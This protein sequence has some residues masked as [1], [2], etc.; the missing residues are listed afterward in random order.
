MH[1]LPLRCS[2]GV[3]TPTGC[4]PL[5][6]GLS[7]PISRP[8]TPQTEPRPH[9]GVGDSL[10]SSP[11]FL[12]TDIHNSTQMSYPYIANMNSLPLPLPAEKIPPTN[13]RYTTS[14]YVVRYQL[15]GRVSLF[16]TPC[17]GDVVCRTRKTKRPRRNRNTVSPRSIIS[18][19]K[20][21]VH[22]PAVCPSWSWLWS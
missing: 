19:P 13:W 8:G 16:L 11:T 21:G 6:A 1:H 20:A 12:G 3:D 17:M 22:V 4:V 5:T 14:L 9:A 10:S 18:P 15:R 7:L 2:I